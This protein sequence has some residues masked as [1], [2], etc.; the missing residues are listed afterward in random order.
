MILHLAP[1]DDWLRDPGRPYSAGSL[2]TDGFIHCSP[3][4]A[5]TLAVA[6]LFFATASDPLMA[7]LIDPDEVEPMVR[8]EA[9]TGPRPPGVAPEVLFPHIYGRL[10]RS[11]VKGLAK[12][13]R[14][15]DGR[16]TRFEPWS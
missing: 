12:L 9:P 16:W 14:G 4:E 5:T 13:E 10:N 6:N 2:L 15:P 7:L 11:A 1:L 8:W 3:D